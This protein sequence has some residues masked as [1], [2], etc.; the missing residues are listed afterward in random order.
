[1]AQVKESEVTGI[2][3]P[4]SAN[5]KGSTSAPPANAKAA[6]QKQIIFRTIRVEDPKL[7]EQMEQA[8]VKFVGVRPGF[9]SQILLAWVLPIGVMILLWTWIG[10]KM[11]GAGQSILSIGKSKAR[12]VVDKDTHVTFDDVAGCE[13]AKFELEEVVEF[14]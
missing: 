6:D 12:L 2:I 1:E 5:T 4:K 14:L 7:T 10:R 9:L 8:G 11:S 13:E 3:V